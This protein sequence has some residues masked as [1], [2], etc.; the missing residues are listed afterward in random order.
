MVNAVGPN[1]TWVFDSVIVKGTIFGSI[2]TVISP[3]INTSIG[4][5]I[6]SIIILLEVG[7]GI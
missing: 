3:T 4:T 7:V 2:V 5:V 6:P 1:I